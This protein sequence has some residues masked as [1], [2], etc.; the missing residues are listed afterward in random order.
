MPCEDAVS[1]FT[2]RPFLAGRSSPDFG[3][4]GATQAAHAG[5]FPPQ[6]VAQLV[7]VHRRSLRRGFGK[8]GPCAGACGQLAHALDTTRGAR[9]EASREPAAIAV[10]DSRRS[11]AARACTFDAIASG[12]GELTD[13][14]SP[15]YPVLNAMAREAASGGP[16][17]RPAKTECGRLSTGLK[18]PCGE[19]ARCS[20]GEFS[21]RPLAAPER[22]P[23]C[24]GRH[25]PVTPHRRWAT[26]GTPPS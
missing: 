13:S 10:D 1:L 9:Y 18:G 25:N 2:A 15:T 3:Q 20:S 4:Q 26:T 5:T 19:S 12:T 11:S 6:S 8:N 14:P 21:P 16:H 24:C 17:H 22:S 23:E 7:S